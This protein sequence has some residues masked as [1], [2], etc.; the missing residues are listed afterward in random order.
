MHAGRQRDR[1]GGRRRRRRYRRA[2][3]A[4]AAGAS[5]C[6]PFWPASTG[7]TRRQA[8]DASGA[9][10][11]SVAS[12][13]D[14]AETDLDRA[15]VTVIVRRSPQH[16]RAPEKPRGRGRDVV[17]A[18]PAEGHPHADAGDARHPRLLPAAWITHGRWRPK[19]QG[20]KLIEVE[21]MGHVLSPTSRYWHV[22]SDALIARHT[23]N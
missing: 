13:G 19:D 6:L 20:A 16:P 15:N 1:V 10:E 3:G 4:A 17:L 21:G 12:A 8:N 23:A 9:R 7:L 14:V 11:R 22:F 18:R 2:V 5:S